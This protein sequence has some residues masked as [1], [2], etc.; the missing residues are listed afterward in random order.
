MAVDTCTCN[1]Q[2]NLNLFLSWRAYK[3]H[4]ENSAGILCSATLQ[5]VVFMRLPL[6]GCVNVRG[7]LICW[8]PEIDKF[9]IIRVQKLTKNSVCWFSLV[10]DKQAFVLFVLTMC[11]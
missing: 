10:S 5:T 11:F 4:K 1:C 2:G 3:K 7:R 9:M 6:C 8:L